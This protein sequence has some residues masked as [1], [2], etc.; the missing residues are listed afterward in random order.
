MKQ[1]T[2]T[3]VAALWLTCPLTAQERP[4]Q[5]PNPVP[6]VSEATDTP[7]AEAAQATPAPPATAGEAKS[8][9]KPAAI[10][11]HELSPWSMF[12]SADPLVKAVMISLV[13]ASLVTWTI[14]LARAT[15]MRFALWRLRRSLGKISAA[16]TLAEAQVT[17]GRTRNILSAMIVAA[18]QEM[19]ASAELSNEDGIKERDAST[20][21]ELARAESRAARQ[22]MGVLATIGATAPFVGLFGTVWGIM[23]SFIGISKSQTTNL[24]V[25][26]PGIA[27]ALLATAFG[28]A[29]AIP[30]VIIYNYFARSTRGYL[31]LVNKAS[32]GVGRL[33]S[34]DLDRTRGRAYPRAAE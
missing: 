17:M 22:S 6:Q 30:A 12:L 19:R 3:V 32:G 13:F 8:L 11:L 5:P 7:K 25:V 15:A 1:V 24:A 21:L 29:A 10:A 34:R 27:E 2:I 23:N 9:A 14:F 16:G 18:T 20:F 26:A 4:V 31:D 28:L 33:L